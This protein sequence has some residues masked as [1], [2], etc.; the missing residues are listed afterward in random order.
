M[1]SFHV[2]RIILFQGILAALCWWKMWIIPVPTTAVWTMS[3]CCNT[4]YTQTYRYLYTCIYS[5]FFFFQD[6]VNIADTLLWGLLKH[7]CVFGDLI[8]LGKMHGS[9]KTWWNMAYFLVEHPAYLC[10]DTQFQYKATVKNPKEWAVL[11]KKQTLRH[12]S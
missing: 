11:H 4:V 8:R 6:L 7:Q 3:Y 1:K 12:V 9:S 10:W 5:F 2:N